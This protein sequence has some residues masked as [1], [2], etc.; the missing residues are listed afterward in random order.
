MSLEIIIGNMFSG[1]TSELIRRLKRYKVTFDK[2][3]IPVGTHLLLSGLLVTINGVV[4]DLG[5]PGW[6]VVRLPKDTNK[7]VR[8]NGYWRRE[9]DRRAFLIAFN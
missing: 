9:G 6:L 1:K 8:R 7:K 5:L 3:R 2:E 4:Y